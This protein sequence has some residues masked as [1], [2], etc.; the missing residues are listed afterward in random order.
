MKEKEETTRHYKFS[1]E[2]LKK[3]LKLEGDFEA[4]GT[5]DKRGED[6]SE[7]KIITRETDEP[8]EKKKP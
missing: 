1:F 6:V 2:D 7:L 8:K 5:K 3:S 4:Y